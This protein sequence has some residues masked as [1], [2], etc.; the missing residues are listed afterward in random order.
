MPPPLTILTFHALDDA[1]TVLSFSPALFERLVRALGAGGYRVM[2]LADAA[3]VLRS[4]GTLPER[5]LVITFDDGYRSVYQAAFPLLRA[6]AMPATV[7]LAVGDAEEGSRCGA[8]D[9]KTR[10]PS[11]EGRP[12]LSWGE[13]REMQR[14]GISFGAHT[15]THPDL[16]RLPPASV[17]REMAASKAVLEEMLGEPVA[18]FAYPFGRY[19][20]LS[21]Q[22]ARRHFACAVSDR[23]G[24][25]GPGSDLHALP[26]VDAYY[27]RHA[28]LV[29][30]LG[31]PWFPGYIRA[32]SVPRAARRGL[33]RLLK[34]YPGRDAQRLPC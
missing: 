1:R 15:L 13:I 30:L 16:T 14:G 32:C 6:L 4:G 23:L 2:R 7:F 3:A 8:G 17:E 31:G 9:A 28:R 11:M 12:M 26:R 24:F 20:A 18:G 5:P 22:L 25:A 21:L 34:W 27:L 10:L 19:D 29:D 33:L